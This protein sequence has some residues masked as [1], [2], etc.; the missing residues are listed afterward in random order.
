MENAKLV[1]AFG[2]GIG[3]KSTLQLFYEAAEFFGAEVAGTRAVVEEGL[4]DRSRQVGQSGISIA[5]NLYV[6]FRYFPEQAS[7][8]SDLKTPTA[9]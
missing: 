1:F 4:L 7:I 5:P 6:A 3:N 9:L 2:R 8:L